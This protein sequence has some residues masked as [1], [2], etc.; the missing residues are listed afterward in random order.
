[1]FTFEE[2]QNEGEF[3][4]FED[5]KPVFDI[6]PYEDKTQDENRGMVSCMVDALN[7][8]HNNE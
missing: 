1:M 7:K 2:S 3:I 8:E 4:I 5:G 6:C